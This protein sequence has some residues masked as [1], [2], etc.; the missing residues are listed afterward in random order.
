MAASSGQGALE[1]APFS[2]RERGWGFLGRTR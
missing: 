1:T 2:R